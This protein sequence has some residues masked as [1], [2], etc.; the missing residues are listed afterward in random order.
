MTTQ[1]T[2]T[3][4]CPVFSENRRAKKIMLSN[5]SPRKMAFNSLPNDKILDLTKLKACADN[6]LDVAKIMI[7]VYD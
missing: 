6:K 4:R 3:M 7:S 1:T 5:V 2:T